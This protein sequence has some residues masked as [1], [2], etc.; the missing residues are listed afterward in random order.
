M[1]LVVGGM[2]P[3]AVSFIGVR[4]RFTGRIAVGDPATV[5]GPE[6]V[7]DTEE[8]RRGTSAGGAIAPLEDTA[9]KEKT[10]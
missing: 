3:T 10:G 1:E 6:Q 4:P 5:P 9:E 8:C 2:V 7:P